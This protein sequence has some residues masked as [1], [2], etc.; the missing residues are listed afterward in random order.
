MCVC[1]CVCVCVCSYCRC[2]KSAEGMQLD[3]GQVGVCC[4]TRTHARAL[5]HSHAHTQVGSLLRQAPWL[6][7]ANLDGQVKPVLE[8]LR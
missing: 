1:V 4:D 2:F 6:L 8:C 7:E 5:A 3:P